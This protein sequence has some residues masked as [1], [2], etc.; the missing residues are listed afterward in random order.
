[1]LRPP[2]TPPDRDTLP[3][4]LRQRLLLGPLLI[5]A[6]LVGG[7]LD[8]RLARTAV[9][10][11]LDWLFFGREMLPPG[12]IVFIFLLALNIVASREVATI[13]IDNGIA[14]SKRAITLASIAGLL[15]SCLVPRSLDGL[16]GAAVLSTGSIVVFLGSL[17]FYSRHR[18]F[19][20]IVA[21]AGGT[22]LAYVYLGLILGFVLAI[23]RDHSVW[24]VLWVV[25]TTKSSDIGAFFT[26]ITLGRHKMIPWLSPG[27]TWEGLAGGIL[28]AAA[29]GAGG[30][31]LLR[32]SFG[33]TRPDILLGA[34]AG[35][36]F[37]VLG[38]AGDL[39][40]SLFKRDAGMKDSGRSVP[41][42]G[43]VLDVMDSVLVVA[44]AAYWLLRLD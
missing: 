2:R 21:A 10:A 8:D 26:G 20:G 34:L 15:L 7:W 40:E 16:T 24:V 3:P 19:E 42:F 32:E 12:L 29:V 17:L 44:P 37:A 28:M 33:V 22:L 13:L 41:G 4:V 9:P 6:L 36:L 18:S 35:A 31:W 25:L 30:A 39:I 11:G 27:K 23:R 1:M 14:A 43:G 5:I 38:Q